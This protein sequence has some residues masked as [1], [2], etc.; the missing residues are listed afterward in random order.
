[1]PNGPTLPEEPS[2][3]KLVIKFLKGHNSDI[4]MQ[5]L[6]SQMP[7]TFGRDKYN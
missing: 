1:L 6:S 7:M 2:V 5:F 4:K 3:S